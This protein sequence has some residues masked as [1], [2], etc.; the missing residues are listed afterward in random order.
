MLE[1]LDKGQCFFLDPSNKGQR[2]SLLESLSRL[3]IVPKQQFKFAEYDQKRVDLK[4]VLNT[5][6]RANQENIATLLN[7]Y[8]AKERLQEVITSKR[9]NLN[10]YKNFNGLINQTDDHTHGIQ[11]G[12]AVNNLKS[13]VKELERKTADATKTCRSLQ[14]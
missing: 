9:E 2:E 10:W 12:E 14:D 5:K 4:N 1:R 7:Q 3:E 11:L 8:K 13:N 6:I